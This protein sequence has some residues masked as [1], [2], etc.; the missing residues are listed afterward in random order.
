MAHTKPVQ[1]FRAGGV[2]CAIWQNELRVGNVTRPVLK[3]TVERRYKDTNGEWKNTGS[4]GRSDIPL[5]LFCLERAF[6]YII[7][8]S[9]TRSDESGTDEETIQ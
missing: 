8:D 1:K 3:C 9:N 4:F 2:S 7:N 6:E 5:L